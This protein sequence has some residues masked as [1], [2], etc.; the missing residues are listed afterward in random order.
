[1]LH[2][3]LRFWPQPLVRSSLL[4]RRRPLKAMAADNQA[5]PVKDP[6][7]RW[8]CIYRR[9]QYRAGVNRLC[10][11]SRRSLSKPMI[12]MVENLQFQV[13]VV[14]RVRRRERGANKIPFPK[15]VKKKMHQLIVVLLTYRKTRGAKCFHSTSCQS[16]K[17]WSGAGNSWASFGRFDTSSCGVTFRFEEFARTLPNGSRYAF[18]CRSRR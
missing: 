16:D 10:S 5:K 15:K 17:N 14:P 18:L 12:H 8:S 9:V 11:F 13:L 2:N 1:M 7:M 3:R 4:K 6:I